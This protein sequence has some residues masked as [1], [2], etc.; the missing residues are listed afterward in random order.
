MLYDVEMQS[1]VIQQNLCTADGTRIHYIERSGEHS[2]NE[3][4]LLH[5]FASGAFL[6]GNLIESIPF[7]G[8]I[9]APDLPGNG[10]SSL[11][12]QE[13]TVEYYVRF[14]KE[15][16]EATTIRHFIGVGVSMGSNI[17]AAFAL[18]YPEKIQRLIL[19]NPIDDTASLKPL[20][21]IAAQPVIAE[22][23]T[24]L[25]P[26]SLNALGK[27]IAKNFYDPTWL[28]SDLISEW[29]DAF[30]KGEVRRWIPKAL[31][32]QPTTIPWQNIS[33]PCIVVFGKNDAVVSEKFRTRLRSTL[34]SAQ[35]VEL[36]QCGHYPHLE[37]PERIEL[38]ILGGN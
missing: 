35:Y 14:L 30:Q 12:P 25:F 2:A 27:Q 33:V 28:K 31:R 23:I 6:W 18:K 21:K 11:P 37:F 4:L 7:P 9:L 29:W 15:F 10:S 8:R 1:K 22:M 26:G 13:P 17:L 20:W 19:T 16:C 3:L 24:K 34:R 38:L 5:S 36:D 32:S